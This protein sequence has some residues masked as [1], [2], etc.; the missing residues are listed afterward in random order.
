MTRKMYFLKD[1]FIAML[2]RLLQFGYMSSLVKFH[3]YCSILAVLCRT[4]PQLI[5]RLSVLLEIR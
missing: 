2:T 1:Q 4:C 3:I 5:L